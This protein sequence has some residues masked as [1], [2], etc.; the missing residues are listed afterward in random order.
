MPEAGKREQTINGNVVLQGLLYDEMHRAK[1]HR[2]PPLQD[3]MCAF[4]R[5]T[6]YTT[7]RETTWRK[8]VSV[9]GNP[10][11]LSH[12]PSSFPPLSLP[13][14][15]S[16]HNSA[17]PTR[18]SFLFSTSPFPCP[19]SVSSLFSWRAGLANRKKPSAHPRD[20]LPP[21]PFFISFS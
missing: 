18:R 10:L 7:K 16:L 13:Y 6:T 14:G 19:L 8:A 21:P 4:L 1:S 17:A 12:S 3:P 2:H 11:F 5:M 20:P 9:F 15:F